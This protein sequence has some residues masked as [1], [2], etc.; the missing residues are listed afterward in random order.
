MNMSAV[1]IKWVVILLAVLNFGFMAFDGGR[2]LVKGDY[3]RPRSGTYSGKLGL[4][5]KLVVKIGIDPE[6]TTMKTIF[7]SWGII[8]LV[9]TFCFVLNMHWASKALIAMNVLSLWYLV[10]GTISS[11]LQVALLLIRKSLL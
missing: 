3:I 5:S 4:W 2:A 7:L 10:P 11:T 6:S 9:I 1:I 8:G